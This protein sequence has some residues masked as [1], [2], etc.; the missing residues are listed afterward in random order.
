MSTT[1]TV[2]LGEKADWLRILARLD[3]L[4]ELGDEPAQWA[5]MLLPILTRFV[6]AFDGAPDI[7]FWTHV[8]N[9]DDRLCGTDFLSGWVTAFCMWDCDG[10]LLGSQGSPPPTLDAHRA[11]GSVM[12]DPRKLKMQVRMYK[13]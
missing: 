7:K 1:N 4:P 11:L 5:K 6:S 2:S 12:S 3:R 8:V 13:C 9:R 10:K